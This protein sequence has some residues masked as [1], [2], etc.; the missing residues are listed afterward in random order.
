MKKIVIFFIVLISFSCK[1]EKFTV[2]SIFLE[3]LKETSTFYENENKKI[4]ATIASRYYDYGRKSENFDTLNKLA[5]KLDKLFINLKVANKEEKIES[6]KK[7]ITDINNLN[8]DYKIEKM[9]LEKLQVLDNE[10][11]YFYLK[12]KLYK[13]QFENY[14]MHLSKL[15]VY[16]GFKAVSPKQA[17]LIKIIESSDIK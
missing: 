5:K 1:K 15:P 11:L 7:Y 17:E 10:T 8:S 9:D 14:E 16:C 2:E 12:F 4:A 13:I 6:F 3:N